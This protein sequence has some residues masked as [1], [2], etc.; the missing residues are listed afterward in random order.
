MSNKGYPFERE[1]LDTF[2]TLEDGTD[3]KSYRVYGSGRNKLS[4]TLDPNSDLSG[5]VNVSLPFLDKPIKVEC[6][7]YKNDTPKKNDAG[8]IERSMRVEK[9]WLDQNL[10][11]AEAKG[12]YSVVAIKFKRSQ[13]NAVHYIIPKDHFIQ[14]LD[15][16]KK[17]SSEGISFDPEWFKGDILTRIKD[18]KLNADR[19]VEQFKN[20]IK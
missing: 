3:G 14:L 18:I 17:L 19:L 7:H 10:E 8:K 9:K 11:E 6:K 4:T 20:K 15:Y 1:T 2:K 16:I 5:D 13:D 12:S